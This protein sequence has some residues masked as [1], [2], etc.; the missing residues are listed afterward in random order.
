MSDD[1]VWL[2]IAYISGS[3]ATYFLMLK[4]TFIDASERTIDTLIDA[5]FIRTR[6]NSDGEVELLRWDAADE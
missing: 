6:K 5:G 4:T 2:F 3:V 1:L